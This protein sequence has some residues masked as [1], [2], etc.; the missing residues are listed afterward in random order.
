V[1]ALPLGLAALL[2]PTL[3]YGGERLALLAAAPFASL[4]LELFPVLGAGGRTLSDRMA[5]VF[6]VHQARP[7][8][9]AQQVVPPATSKRWVWVDGLVLLMVG[10]PLLVLVFGWDAGKGAAGATAIMVALF[11]ALEGTVVA[12]NQRTIAMGALAPPP[13]E[14][15]FRVPSF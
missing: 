14:G 4:A 9:W 7:V 13:A 1:F 6:W 15:G 11:V 5:G 8:A 12:R 2:A 3:E 10:S